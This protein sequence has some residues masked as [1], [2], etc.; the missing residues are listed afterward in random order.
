MPSLRGGGYG[1]E[2]SANDGC[3]ELR[4]LSCNL[5]SM[6]LA[7]LH[8]VLSLADEERISIIAFQ[9]TKHPNNGFS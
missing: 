5:T 4:L 6:T 3:M 2:F 1:E 8:T 9:E 7:R